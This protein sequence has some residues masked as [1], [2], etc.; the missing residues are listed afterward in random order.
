VDFHTHP[1]KCLND[2]T[3]TVG[4]GSPGDM[5]NIYLGVLKGNQYHMIYSREGTYVISV[6]PSFRRVIRAYR[7]VPSRLKATVK[8]EITDLHEKF[9]HTPSMT[10][11]QYK[12]HWFRIVRKY[13]FKVRFYPRKQTPTLKIYL[14]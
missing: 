7:G 12:R 14:Y 8:Q 10:Y 1:A 5:I 9:K 4:V 3:C 13:G 11:A 6:I 2:D